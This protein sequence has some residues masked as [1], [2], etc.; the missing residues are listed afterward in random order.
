MALDGV[1]A[2]F[3]VLVGVFSSDVASPESSAIVTG[4]VVGDAAVVPGALLE[5]DGVEGDAA[6]PIPGVTS[7]A[8]S[9]VL[10]IGVAVVASE[11]EN[12]LLMAEASD[13]PPTV[14]R[15]VYAITWSISRSSN[16]AMP[17][18]LSVPM[19]SIVVPSNVPVP[20]ETERVNG[21]DASSPRMESLPK[22]SWTLTT[23]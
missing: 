7:D 22:S 12:V 20:L 18:P 9:V 5:L 8:S 4:A 21:K 11:T 17:L 13:S 3:D 23:G 2:T 19:S 14:A 16:T 1:F 15:S 10:T 6:V